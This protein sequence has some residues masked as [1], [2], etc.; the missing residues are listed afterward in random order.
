LVKIL[1]FFFF[2]KFDDC[3]QSKREIIVTEYA[4][5]FQTFRILTNFHTQKMM[6]EA[7]W[8]HMGNFSKCFIVLYKHL[9]T[10]KVKRRISHAYM[11][12]LVS[13]F[14]YFFMSFESWSLDQCFHFSFF[15]C[16]E[17]LQCYYFQRK[18]NQL[19]HVNYN[20]NLFNLVFNSWII[21]TFYEQIVCRLF[22]CSI[23]VHNNF[24]SN[25]VFLFKSFQKH[26]DH[27]NHKRLTPQLIIHIFWISTLKMG[28][29]VEKIE[30]STSHKLLT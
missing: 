16:F 4:F 29:H 5:L 27:S 6:L 28:I 22:K 24:I 25:M 15:F 12:S 1:Q 18:K 9:C 17:T 30:N 2:W 3:S 14:F 10:L 11:W 20:Q 13:Q 8:I 23:I 26:H 19:W 7:L 21:E